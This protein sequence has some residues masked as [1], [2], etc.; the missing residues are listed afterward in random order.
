VRTGPLKPHPHPSVRVEP[1]PRDAWFAAVAG[2][3][4]A[5]PDVARRI[6]T[7][8]PVAGFAG[9]YTDNAAIAVGRGV[10]TDDWL[11]IS[12]VSVD[13][14]HRRQGLARAVV[15]TLAHWAVE[16]GATRG[17][18]QVEAHNTAAATMYAHLG[19]DVHHTYRTW[20]AP[21]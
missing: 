11:G 21:T 12:L 8:V 17:Y 16:H 2:H 19:F 5:L 13:P 4:G 18:L 15:G 1:A 7:G 6:L 10:I 20:T 3:K 9:C 14:A